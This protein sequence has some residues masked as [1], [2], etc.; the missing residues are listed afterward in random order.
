MN[1]GLNED[2]HSLW[3]NFLGGDDK[4][5]R[6]I[7]MLHIGRLMSYGKKIMPEASL[8]EDALQE[9]FVDLYEKRNKPHKP[10]DNPGG[11]LMVALRNNL[12]QKKSGKRRQERHNLLPAEVQEFLVEYSFQDH[13]ISQEVTGATLKKLRNAI[14]N[15]TAGQKEVI[16]LRFDEGLPYNEVAEIM[17]ISIDS[18][19]KQVFRAISS[20]RSAL[21]SSNLTLF[22]LFF[23]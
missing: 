10:V 18:A 15:L 21:N 2:T 5:F 17:G 9:I 20:L 23:R 19:R 13:L 4:A 8:L 22:L 11:Y 12:L 3:L 1:T 7:Y 16:Y 14:N 6:K